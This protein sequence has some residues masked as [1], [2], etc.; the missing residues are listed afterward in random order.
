MYDVQSPR[1]S[2]RIESRADTSDSMSDQRQGVNASGSHSTQHD[3]LDCNVTKTTKSKNS[4]KQSS[5]RRGN[6]K[7]SSK[8]DAPSRKE[9]DELKQLMLSLSN[10]IDLISTSTSA[11]VSVNDSSNDV[12]NVSNSMNDDA[13]VTH[14]VNHNDEKK[15]VVDLSKSVKIADQSFQ[16]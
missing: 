10:T 12:E 6:T 3:T 14:N 13:N 5:S 1:R 11:V 2:V 15:Q 7:S 8:D 4:I 16:S 9:F